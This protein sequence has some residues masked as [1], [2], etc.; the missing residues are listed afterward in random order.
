LNNGSFF[1]AL[2]VA[3]PTFLTTNSA[4]ATKYAGEPYY[5]GVG[6]RAIALGGAGVG[7]P[8]DAAAAFWN[9]AALASAGRGELLVQH[10]ETFGSL[11]DHDVIAGALP[12]G[13]VGRDWAWSAYIARLGGGGIQLT[14]YDS[15]TNRPRVGSEASHSNWSFAVSAART[16]GNWG[17]LAVTAKVLF[18]ELPGN[19]AYGM[20]LDLSWWRQWSWA[21]AGIKIA[22]AT[23]TFLSYDSGTKETIAPHVNW[24]GEIDLP[25]VAKGVAA[26]VA[27]EAETYFE[28]RKTAAQYWRGAVSVDLH[29]GLEVSY[30]DHLFARAGSDAGQLALGAGFVAGRWGI[31]GALV[32]HQALDSSYRLS[33]R[34]LLR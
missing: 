11:L 21:R 9:P 5:I 10:A 32:N 20:G 26:T 24:G 7:S 25:T 15:T 4:S 19:S 13:R 33:L 30:R 14:Q 18:N 34:L 17:N 1:C 29:L 23:S 31:D 8:P 27:G 28:N 16:M 22:D 12:A 6:G 3:L 2:L